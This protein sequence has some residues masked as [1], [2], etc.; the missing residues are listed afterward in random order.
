MLVIPQLFSPMRTV[1]L[2]RASSS[3]FK[4]L[5]FSIVSFRSSIVFFLCIQMGR[6]DLQSSYCGKQAVIGSSFV[7]ESETSSTDS[8]LQLAFE[9]ILRW[10]DSQVLRN[11][12]A[13]SVKLQEFNLPGAGTSA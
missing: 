2:S 6:F 12:Y 7:L 13:D 8:I 5:K 10:K 11:V 1:V 9:N 3:F 4:P